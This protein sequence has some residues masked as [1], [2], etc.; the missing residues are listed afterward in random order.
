[1]TVDTKTSIAALKQGDI[2]TAC[3]YRKPG[4]ED[5]RSLLEPYLLHVYEGLLWMYNYNP[6]YIIREKC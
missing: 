3:I 2:M 6:E 5:M 1:M 4:K